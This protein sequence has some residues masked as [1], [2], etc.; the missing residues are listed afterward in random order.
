MSLVMKDNLTI[1]LKSY[2]TDFEKQ[3]LRKHPVVYLLIRIKKSKS[4]R[5]QI[6]NT[7]STQCKKTDLAHIG[8]QEIVETKRLIRSQK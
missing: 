7:R 2:T 6:I 1:M 8:H 5:W 3:T 4:S